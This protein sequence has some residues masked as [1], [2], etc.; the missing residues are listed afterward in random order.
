M[1]RLSVA[2][3]GPPEVRH[4]GRLV[5]FPTRKALALLVYLLVEGG[6][7][8]REKLLALLW[9]E[10]DA[11]ASRVTLRSTLVRLR[12]ALAETA[13]ESQL[14]VTRD[15]VGF[16]VTSDV[17]LD[18]RQLQFACDQARIP[19]QPDA[20]SRDA[21]ATLVAALQSAADR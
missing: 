9:P 13:G 19:L 4:D 15:V 17:E 7:P 12:R 3:L 14:V 10:G 21:R 1:A 5:A 18:L 2:V 8:T 11:H 20:S 16:T 6:F